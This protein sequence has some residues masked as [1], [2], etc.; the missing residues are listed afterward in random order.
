MD[1]D[2]ATGV[3]VESA[4]TYISIVFFAIGLLIQSYFLLKPYMEDDEIIHNI[5]GAAGASLVLNVFLQLIVC[6]KHSL[7]PDLTI[8]L[9]SSIF[10]YIVIFAIAFSYI[11][12]PVISKQFLVIYNLV[13][14]YYVYI[15][16]W[17]LDIF[18]L[19]TIVVFINAFTRYQPP[20]FVKFLFYVW[21]LM[22][23]IIMLYIVTQDFGPGSRTGLFEQHP[24]NL[25]TLIMYTSSAMIYL[26]LCVDAS[27][28]LIPILLVYFKYGAI[29]GAEVNKASERS[30]VAIE[31][32]FSNGSVRMP[33][34]EERMAADEARGKQQAEWFDKLLQKY[35]AAIYAKYQDDQQNPINTII[36]VTTI[37]FILEANFMILHMNDYVLANIIF[38]L[39]RYQFHE[40]ITKI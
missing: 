36:I 27:H 37:I 12:L 11:I 33:T 29:F 1:L 19:P 40:D 18:L 6:M 14:I 10:F 25:Q 38:L 15:N 8:F 39:G 3:L 9:I 7:P 16:H 5:A 22:M 32:N 30:S 2:P 31:F 24:L 17:H 4:N 21:Y 34:A 28:I 20:N 35:M 13:F 26:Y 23:S